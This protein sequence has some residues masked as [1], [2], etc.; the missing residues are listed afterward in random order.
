MQIHTPARA[1]NTAECF[2]RGRRTR[3]GKR[4][5]RGEKKTKKRRY[6]ETAFYFEVWCERRHQRNA[7]SACGEQSHG[8]TRTPREKVRNYTI[9]S[10]PLRRFKHFRLLSLTWNWI[11]GKICLIT[12]T[13]VYLEKCSQRRSEA[14]LQSYPITARCWD[15]STIRG[16]SYFITNKYTKYLNVFD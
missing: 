7:E 12:I 14:F 3:G 4:K 15:C 11:C 16:W 1:R 10:P 8:E 13:Q 5:K 2:Y 9:T 6:S